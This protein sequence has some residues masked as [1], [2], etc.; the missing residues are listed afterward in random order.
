MCAE[1]DNI[2]DFLDALDPDYNEIYID[3]N[4]TNNDKKNHNN[5]QRKKKDINNKD[6]STNIDNIWKTG[7]SRTSKGINKANLEMANGSNY[8]PESR[9]LAKRFTSDKS[10]NSL[11]RSISNYV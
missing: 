9:F 4:I 7:L 1:F 5:N 8:L 6:D 10:G 2:N 11:N 3:L